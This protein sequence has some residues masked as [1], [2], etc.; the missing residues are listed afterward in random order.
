[1]YYVSLPV[2]TKMSKPNVSE[3]FRQKVKQ[4]FGAKKGH[5]IPSS[6]YEGPKPDEFFFHQELLQV[7]GPMVLEIVLLVSCL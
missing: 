3:G 1:M 6:V 5:V 4:F 7:D 2:V